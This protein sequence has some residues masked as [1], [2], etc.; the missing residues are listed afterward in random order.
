MT[1]SPQMRG[2]YSALIKMRA[3]RWMIKSQDE[4]PLRKSRKDPGQ[5]KGI[6]VSNP[7]SQ[8]ANKE[9]SA[10]GRIIQQ[11]PRD[12]AIRHVLASPELLVNILRFVFAEVG[13]M[14]P[15]VI[16]RYT[17]YGGYHLIQKS[18]DEAQKLRENYPRILGKLS[19]VSK[20]FHEASSSN[21][22]WRE[23]C[24]ERWKRVYGFRRRW[25]D[26]LFGFSNNEFREQVGFWKRRFFMEEP[27][28]IE[29][30][31]EML[32]E[33][34]SEDDD[35]DSDLEYYDPDF[36]DYSYGDWHDPYDGFDG[37]WSDDGY[38]S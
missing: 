29:L 25:E 15:S 9:G 30:N 33:Y 32:E 37:Y 3:N 31:E 6:I 16:R 17:T 28:V 36:D 10:V 11:E 26:A 20:C 8:T 38:Y 35:P 24:Q 5:E 21:G 34:S 1:L 2:A 13:D 22:L 14:C 18:S 27:D 19:V 7:R 4:L 23:I 12:D